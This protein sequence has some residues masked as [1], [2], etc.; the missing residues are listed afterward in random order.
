MNSSV[1]L[2][3]T[4]VLEWYKKSLSPFGIF[5][6]ILCG[7]FLPELS[8]INR[9]L[10]IFFPALISLIYFCVYHQEM[11]S[12]KFTICYVNAFIHGVFVFCIVT[13]YSNSGIL[14][15]LTLVITTVYITI[16]IILF[17]TLRNHNSVLLDVDVTGDYIPT[18][19]TLIAPLTCSTCSICLDPLTENIVKLNNCSHCFHMSC[20]S[21][22]LIRKRDCPLCREATNPV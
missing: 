7:M 3:V 21:K 18:E 17:K 1:R 16:P 2:F 13:A 6:G 10:L 15:L 11:W 9:V 22:W 12:V 4:V 5:H 14:I 8:K 19:T 20:I